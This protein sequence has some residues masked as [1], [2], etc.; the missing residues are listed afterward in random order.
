MSFDALNNLYP[1]L[2]AD[3]V[4]Y[5]ILDTPNPRSLLRQHIVTMIVAGRTFRAPSK[6]AINGIAAVVVD[7]EERMW[8]TAGR[9]M[10]AHAD[11]ATFADRLAAA[12]QA[13]S[14]E[15]LAMTQLLTA[16]TSSA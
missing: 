10:E 8:V 2:T 14:A 9:L 6:L 13:I 4:T 15:R 12:M 1:G 11:W 16:T 7:L 3:A 5:I